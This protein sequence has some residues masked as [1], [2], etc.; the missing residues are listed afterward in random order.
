MKSNQIFNLTELRPEL[1]VP[2]FLKRQ[3]QIRIKNRESEL[4]WVIYS[5]KIRTGSA[6]SENNGYRNYRFWFD[7]KS[8]WPVYRGLNSSF[9]IPYLCINLLS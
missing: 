3:P 4:R 8:C 9:L 2:K 5:K 7:K 1:A 6:N